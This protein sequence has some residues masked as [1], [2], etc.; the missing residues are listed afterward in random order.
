[1]KGTGP[2]P[3]AKIGVPFVFIGLALLDAGSMIG[4]AHAFDW[5]RYGS[6]PRY[7]TAALLHDLDVRSPVV[8]WAFLQ[9]VIDGVMRSSAALVLTAT[10]T[11]VVGGAV[12][13]V[14]REDAR[15]VR[16]SE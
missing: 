3:L 13:R 9:G 16:I 4:L 2:A 7:A 8:T 6:W 1:M 15:M 10:G 5:L 12:Y 11:V 14:R